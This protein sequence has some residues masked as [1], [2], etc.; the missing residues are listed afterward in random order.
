MCHCLQCNATK[1]HTHRGTH[2]HAHKLNCFSLANSHVELQP[3]EGSASQRRF[4][5]PYEPLSSGIDVI[6]IHAV[7]ISD[8]F[9][10][11]GNVIVFH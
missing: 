2:T 7:V 8:T 11:S 1:G 10:G 5:E 3:G 6:Y 4:D 9:R